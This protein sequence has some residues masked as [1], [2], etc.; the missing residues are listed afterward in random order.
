MNAYFGNSLLCVVLFISGLSYASTSIVYEGKYQAGEV[1]LEVKEYLL[2]PRV[3][4]PARPRKIRYTTFAVELA[5]GNRILNGYTYLLVDG[6]PYHFES[7]QTSFHQS[8]ILKLEKFGI[9]Q[10]TLICHYLDSEKKAHLFEKTLNL[11]LEPIDFKIS[12]AEGKAD[13]N[14]FG[15]MEGTLKEVCLTDPLA[16]TFM[17]TLFG[18]ANEVEN[19]KQQYP[20]WT[21]TEVFYTEQTQ[22]QDEFQLGGEMLQEGKKTPLYYRLTRTRH[23]ELESVWHTYQWEKIDTALSG[24]SYFDK[25]SVDLANA[26][27]AKN[28]EWLKAEHRSSF[29]I[30]EIS[31]TSNHAFHRE[32][33]LKG[34]LLAGDIIFG[35][36][37]I[38][39]SHIQTPSYSESGKEILF[40][41]E[42]SYEVSLQENKI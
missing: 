29:Y 31:M 40:K 21:L 37:H 13:P 17:N 41:L 33:Q 26:M 24:K 5:Q 23:I 10:L 4:P 25:D 11:K 36:V 15:V 9:Y 1:T 35:S 38:Q 18:V 7:R 2:I 3:A 20:S 32:Y 6:K 14:I 12:I 8:E 28:A 39:I 27:I 42:S 19:I 34:E 30:R 22:D 16:S